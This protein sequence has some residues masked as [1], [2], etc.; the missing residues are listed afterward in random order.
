MFICTYLLIF[1]CAIVHFICAHCIKFIYCQFTA[2]LTRA[3]VTVMH[4][5]LTLPIKHGASSDTVDS[6]S[7]SCT[8]Y[9]VINSGSFISDPV[10]IN[11]LNLFSII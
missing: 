8:L 7:P 3:S 2:N 4:D 10:V 11:Y 6:L 5:C 1:N 9:R